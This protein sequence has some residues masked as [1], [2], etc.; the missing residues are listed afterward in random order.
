MRRAYS[1]TTHQ[2][3]AHLLHVEPRS[4][5][6]LQ[7]SFVPVCPA[8]LREL[9]ARGVHAR[10][11]A[12]H[13][14]KRGTGLH[15]SGC[16][17]NCPGPTYAPA[18]RQGFPRADIDVHAVRRDRHRLACLTNDHKAL[19]ERLAQL[20]A[21]LHHAQARWAPQTASSRDG[22]VSL[23]VGAAWGH[24][25]V[26]AWVGTHCDCGYGDWGQQSHS[27]AGWVG[28]WEGGWVGGGGGA[29]RK[30]ARNRY[31]SITCALVVCECTPG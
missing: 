16:A 22:L 9:A 25:G 3:W 2:S 27:S 13:E 17:R 30:V 26:A 29:G 4:V 5:T 14:T 1:A 23:G 12:N 6:C 15:C 31:A 8:P 10:F 18:P 20:L 11:H 19:T 28:W 21:A 24:T 7:C